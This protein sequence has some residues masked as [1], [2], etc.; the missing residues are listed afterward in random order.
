MLDQQPVSRPAPGFQRLQPTGR[1]HGDRRKQSCQGRGSPPIKPE[2]SPF[3]QP[4]DFLERL[5]RAGIMT[6]LED[7]DRN[8][9]QLGPSICKTA[10]FPAGF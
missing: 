1:E 4:R 2:P 7:E 8:A 10:K 9:M 6:L 3:G 5:F